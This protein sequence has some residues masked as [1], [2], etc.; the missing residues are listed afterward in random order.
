MGRHIQTTTGRSQLLEP[1]GG[2]EGGEIEREVRQR[3]L[4]SPPSEA[5]DSEDK[6][7]NRC[8]STALSDLL[9]SLLLA[10]AHWKVQRVREPQDVIHKVSLE[11]TSEVDKRDGI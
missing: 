7:G 1:S 5:D 3:V 10:E 6:P 2:R 4:P 8:S 11:G 9:L